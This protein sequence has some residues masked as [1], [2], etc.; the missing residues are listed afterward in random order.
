MKRAG[1]KGKMTDRAGKNETLNQRSV[2]TKYR[3][4]SKPS[5]KPSAS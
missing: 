5:T 1:E 2:L 4:Q 3:W